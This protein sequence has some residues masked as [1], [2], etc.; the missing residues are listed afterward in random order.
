MS[1][2][3]YIGGISSGKSELAEKLSISYASPRLYIATA[4]IKDSETLKRIEKHKKRRKNLFKTEEEPLYPE[5]FFMNT[6]NIILL[7]CLTHFYNNIFYYI[8]KPKEREKRVQEFC[9]S[10]D[11]FTGSIILVTNEV[12]LGGIPANKLAREFADFSGWANSLI[13]SICKEVYFIVAGIQ[14][15]IK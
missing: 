15:K 12:G 6:Y 9:E 2:V 13:A 4:D 7:D 10:L 11:N 14:I 1:K 5:K 3:L 8:S